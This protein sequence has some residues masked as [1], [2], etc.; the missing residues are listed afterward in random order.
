MIRVFVIDDEPVAR[1]NVEALLG[2]CSDVEVRLSSG[3][4][5]AALRRIREE[6][7]DLVFLDV[8][9]PRLD[10]MAFLV[11]MR[12]E[13]PEERRPYVVLVTAF[14]RYALE[15]F[16][17]E[18]LDYLVKPFDTPRFET[19]LCRARDRIRQ[20][21]AVAEARPEVTAAASSE[22]LRF[23]VSGGEVL[24]DPCEICWVEAVDHYVLLHAAMRSYLVRLT[25]SEAERR[26]SPHGSVRVHRGAIVNIACIRSHERLA[27][28]SRELV[29]SEGSRVRVSRRR[30]REIRERIE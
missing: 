12:E 5:V 30:W 9:M 3:D 11:R 6:P 2:K 4:P 8:R 29:L 19:A 24:L 1:Q 20:R 15:A 17:Y 7:P 26:L 21:R 18:A 22:R 16:E 27:D 28:G 14:D 25:M 23:K 10:G 13:L